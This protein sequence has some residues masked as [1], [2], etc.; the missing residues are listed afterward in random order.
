[1]KL[2]HPSPAG[3][4]HGSARGAIARSSPAM[5][6]DECQRDALLN[7]AHTTAVHENSEIKYANAGR[8]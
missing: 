4:P 3:L 8:D 1:M 7:L 6:V 5:T 2:I